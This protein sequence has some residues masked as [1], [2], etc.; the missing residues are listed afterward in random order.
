Q[1]IIVRP[2]DGYQF[3]E[4]VRVTVGTMEENRR[5]IEALKKTIPPHPS[6]ATGERTRGER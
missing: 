3:A 1:G 4:H 6:L 5:F 2:M